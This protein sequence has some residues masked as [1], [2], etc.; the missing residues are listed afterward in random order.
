LPLRPF[1]FGGARTGAGRAWLFRGTLLGAFVLLG[2]AALVAPSR[3]GIFDVR[4]MTGLIPLYVA[5]LAGA[6]DALPWRVALPA[7]SAVLLAQG[8]P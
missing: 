5:L 7:A 6:V 1:S 2:V 8:P 3:T 4:Y